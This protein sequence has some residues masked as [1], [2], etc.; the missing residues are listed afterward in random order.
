MIFWH[1]LLRYPRFFVSSLLGLLLIILNPIIQGKKGTL[2]RI[3][4]SLFGSGIFLFWV[5]KEMLRLE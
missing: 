5:V 2:A 3:I 4:F 1:N